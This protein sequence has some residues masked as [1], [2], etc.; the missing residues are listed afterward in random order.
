MNQV[1][2]EDIA[3]IAQQFA[4]IAGVFDPKN[5][6]AI[7]LLVQAGT[8]VNTLIH[9]IRSMN[10][11]DSKRVWNEVSTDFKQSFAAFE[12]SLKSKE[13]PNA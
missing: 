1:T 9:K 8:T 10:E 5:A 2:P 12:A 6:A 7:A 11:A 3:L 13:N 4:A